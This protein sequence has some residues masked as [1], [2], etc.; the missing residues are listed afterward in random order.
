MEFDPSTRFSFTQILMVV[1]YRHKQR[2]YK[3]ETAGAKTNNSN[4]KSTTCIQKC[5][6]WKEALFCNLNI[7]FL[8][9]ELNDALL[10]SSEIF[11]QFMVQN[12]ENH[13][14]SL[15]LSTKMYEDVFMCCCISV[16]AKPTLVLTKA[17]I[18]QKGQ[19]GFKSQLVNSPCV[20]L[21]V[22]VV[23]ILWMWRGN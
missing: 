20:S 9:Q 23:Y 19:T 15:N 12:Y 22:N 17:F 13:M 1:Q 6:M 21:M 2:C 18:S 14:R 4:K 11:I 10:W 8:I 5:H 7:F 16:Y 3:Y